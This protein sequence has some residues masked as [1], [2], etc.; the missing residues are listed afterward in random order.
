LDL[1]GINIGIPIIRR[2]ERIHYALPYTSDGTLE[3]K[4]QIFQIEIDGS[5]WHRNN[6]QRDALK[7]RIVLKNGHIPLRVEC[8]SIQEAPKIAEELYKQL[9]HK[10]I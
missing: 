10:C 4:G 6:Q 7:E 9:M 8:N 3:Y 1:L 5:Y 2:E